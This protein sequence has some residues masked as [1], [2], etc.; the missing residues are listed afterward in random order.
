MLRSVLLVVIPLADAACGG[1]PIREPD[2][3]PGLE[4][5]GAEGIP[6]NSDGGAALT[7]NAPPSSGAALVDSNT[8]RVDITVQVDTS[9][10]LD[11]AQD[12]VQVGILVRV[13]DA[14]TGAIVTDAEVEGGLL[15]RPFPFTFV[16]PTGYAPGNVYAATVTGY[17]RM[18][19]F[20]VVRG[21]DRLTGVVL[22]GPS[23][24]SFTVSMGASSATID[25]SP[26]REAE[27]TSSFCASEDSGGAT[28][29]DWCTGGDDEGS[30]ILTAADAYGQ[31]KTFPQPEAR[32]LMNLVLE[33]EVA[34]GSQG[35]TGTVSV[36]ALG[37]RGPCG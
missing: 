2:Q 25:W 7:D 9:G 36:L 22:L 4:D 3:G 18:W 14:T 1:S 13:A 23:Y 16:P 31:A 26:A 15:G 32:Y 29:L 21:S 8:L 28:A 6:D 33:S 35:G 17:E 27:V 5:G 24:P 34:V 30:L 10:A 12:G 19:E 37:E 20:S 11:A